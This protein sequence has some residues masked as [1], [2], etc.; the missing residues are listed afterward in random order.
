MANNPSSSTK[1]TIN[2]PPELT[3][4]IQRAKL[5]AEAAG[6]AFPA[7]LSAAIEAAVRE[8]LEKHAPQ[9]LETPGRGR[10]RKTVRK[11]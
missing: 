6:E 10:P 7:T 3:R 4:A 2:L 5:D 8:Y 1:K 9:A 11:P